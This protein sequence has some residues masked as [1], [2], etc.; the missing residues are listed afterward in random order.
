MVLMLSNLPNPLSCPFP[1]RACFRRACV[2]CNATAAAAL[3]DEALCP[4]IKDT[5]C[6]NVKSLK[7]R[8]SEI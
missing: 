8:C 4:G 5:Q 7:M 1:S 3:E 6:R 2:V